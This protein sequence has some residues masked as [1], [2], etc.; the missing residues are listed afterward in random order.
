MTI[1]TLYDVQNNFRAQT[2]G[3]L[4]LTLGEYTELLIPSKSLT[5]ALFQNKKSSQV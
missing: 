2:T 4:C 5:T 3:M 1:M